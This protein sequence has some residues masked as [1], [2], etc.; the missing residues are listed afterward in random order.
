M[1][2]DLKIK[3]KKLL[4]SLFLNSRKSNRQLAKDINLSKET[5][6]SKISILEQ[7]EYIKSF[8]LKTNYAKLR[9]KEINLYIRLR[10]ASPKIIEDMTEYFIN[11]KNSTWVGKS[12]GRYDFKI[13][14]ILKN[15]DKIH[16][17]IAKIH[18]KFTKEIEDINYLYVM[19]KFKASSKLFLENMFG[20][21][22]LLSSTTFENI[23]SNIK[24]NEIINLDQIDKDLLYYFSQ[25]PKQPYANLTEKLNLTAE[26]IKYR[27]SRLEKQG[28]ITGYSIV[29]NGNAFDKIWAVAFLN[30]NPKKIEKFKDYLKKQ[31]FLSNYVE[32]I[33]N[34]NFAV[35]F[36]ANNIKELNEHLNIIRYKFSEDI[37]NFDFIILFDKNVYKFPRLPECIME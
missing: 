11:H 27:I 21:E 14:L 12:F 29:L 10:N 18:E 31:D 28:I 33:G 13:A 30:I 34:W 20:K 9:Y 6:S 35:Q 17:I 16:S 1:T 15:I 37:Q 22:L 5:I 32:T 25:N 3:D 8:S 24:N 2:D 36:F 4:I 19:D 23:N 26:A 7:K